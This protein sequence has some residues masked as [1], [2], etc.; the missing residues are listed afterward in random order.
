MA[1]AESGVPEATYV[2]NYGHGTHIAGIIGATAG[3]GEGIA[4]I[5]WRCAIAS[6][7]AFLCLA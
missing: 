2:D 5:D 6:P 1:A 3:N 7:K 4:G